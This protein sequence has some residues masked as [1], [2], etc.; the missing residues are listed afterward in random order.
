MKEKVIAWLNEHGSIIAAEAVSQRPVNHLDFHA[1]NVFGEPGMMFNPIEE[2]TWEDY[3]T[4]MATMGEL[5]QQCET[6]CKKSF[7]YYRYTTD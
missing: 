3:N 5:E 6:S 4:Q 2:S 1:T 7:K